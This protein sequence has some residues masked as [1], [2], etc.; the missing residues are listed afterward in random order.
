MNETRKHLLV[1][2][3][4]LTTLVT[5]AT[6]PAGAAT[7]TVTSSPPYRSAATFDSCTEQRSADFPEAT[8]FTET[9]SADRKLGRGAGS[10]SMVSADGGAS[11][12]V[13]L[14]FYDSTV[15]DRT[16]VQPG[17]HSITVTVE[18]VLNRARIAWSRNLL[19]S[20]WS[21]VTAGLCLR[22]SNGSCVIR[23]FEFLLDNFSDLTPSGSREVTGQAFILTGTATS[24]TGFPGGRYQMEAEIGGFQQLGVRDADGNECQGGNGLLSA[25]YDG[26]ITG[27]TV[28]SS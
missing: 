15:T 24:E 9:L 16:H 3:V 28:V 11:D 27:M 14:H 2:A 20:S 21:A 13:A 17:S 4:V 19:S 22:G 23:E 12:S 18:G 1:V 10:G 26:V 6:S 25:S 7:R 8:C 5:L